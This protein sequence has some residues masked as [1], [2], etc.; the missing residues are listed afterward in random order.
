MQYVV[1]SITYSIKGADLLRSEL[2]VLK[3][4]LEKHCRGVFM[5]P[6]GKVDQANTQLKVAVAYEPGEQKEHWHC[7]AMAVVRS[8]AFLIKLQSESLFVLFMRFV[9]VPTLFEA[10]APF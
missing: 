10:F 1:C 4:A 7:Q 9:T 6:P 5:D 3:T 2:P 8:H